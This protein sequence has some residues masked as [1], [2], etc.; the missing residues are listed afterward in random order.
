MDRLPRELALA[1]GQMK[2]VCIPREQCTPNQKGKA[3]RKS[4]P[5]DE[6]TPN[7]KSAADLAA[8]TNKD[9]WCLSG[10]SFSP[11][12]SLESNRSM[13]E[14]SKGEYD[15][16]DDVAGRCFEENFSSESRELLER[17]SRKEHGMDSPCAVIM[18]A[19][20]YVKKRRSS[21]AEAPG[22]YFKMIRG[23]KIAILREPNVKLKASAYLNRG[24]VFAASAVF[25]S[26]HDGRV[27]VQLA[28][29]RGFVCATSRGDVGRAVVEAID[30]EEFDVLV[31]LGAA[32]QDGTKKAT[33]R[34]ATDTPQT[35]TP[36]KKRNKP[37]EFGTP[38]MFDSKALF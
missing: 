29:G 5:I 18:K 16:D 6:N 35:A 12:L 28:N 1:L 25:T 22:K 14:R 30:Q 4:I 3:R 27:Y 13:K 8:S 31:H 21:V 9:N 36:F 23:Q 15:S 33:K 10:M 11:Q 20:P 17:I 7:R 19:S 38:P 2:K 24:A 34:P 32:V 37:A 26:Q